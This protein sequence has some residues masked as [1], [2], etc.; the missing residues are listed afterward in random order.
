MIPEK[1]S[2]LK[3]TAREK[4][5]QHIFGC[6]PPILEHLLLCLKRLE[7]EEIAYISVYGMFRLTK[8]FILSL[9]G[10]I[11]TYELLI[12]NAFPEK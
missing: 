4:I 2:E 1:I 11:L 5:N 8:T 12:I 9:I 7:T 6:I 3:M 10:I